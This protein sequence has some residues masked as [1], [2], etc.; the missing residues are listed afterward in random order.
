MSAIAVPL[1]DAAAAAPPSPAAAIELSIIIPT[2]NERGNVQ[3]MIERLGRALAGIGW[4]A[5]FVDDDSTDGTREEVRRLAA[6]DRRIR[7]L[8]RIGRRGLASACIE[9]ALATTAPFMAVIDADLQHDETLLLRMLATLRAEPL[10][11]VV[12]SRYVEGGGIGEWS[13]GRAGASRLAT[14]LSRLICKADIADPMSGFFMIRRDAFEAA[15]R[16]LS[17]VGFKILLDLFASAPAPLRFKELPYRFGQRQHGSSKLDTLVAWEYLM[18]IAD[19]LIGHMVPVRFV[20]FAAVGGIGLFVHLAALWLGLRFAGFEFTLA[21]SVATAT[22]MVGNFTLNNLFT[23]ADRRLRGFA[24]LRG[25]VTF[26]LV[27]GLGAVANVGVARVI[28]GQQESWWIAGVA[29]AIV[30]SVWNYAV[31]SVVTWQKK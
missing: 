23:Y 19:K 8:H 22:A 7:L 24:F 25:L 9:G 28:F 30:G 14:R 20:L 10:D 11:L 15:V 13:E 16:R 27:C 29:G 21:Q 31:T 4:E 2:L 18:L 5:I 1:P 6:T 3:P 12:G 26:S 17:A